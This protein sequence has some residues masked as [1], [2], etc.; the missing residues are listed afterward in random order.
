MKK[1]Y[2]KYR[3]REIPFR[4]YP[5][6]EE[7]ADEGIIEYEDGDIKGIPDSIF[8]YYYDDIPEEFKNLLLELYYLTPIENVPSIL[9]KG[10]LCYNEAYRI[11][12][13]SIAEDSVQDIRENKN[14]G[15]RPIHDYV[16][17]YFAKKTPMHYKRKEFEKNICYLCVDRS[18]LLLPGVYISDGNAAA[19]ETRF[20]CDLRKLKDI[21]WEL[22]PPEVRCYDGESKRKKQAEVLVPSKVPPDRIQKIVLYDENA[23]VSLKQKIEL[24]IPI[25]I[26]KSFYFY[27]DTQ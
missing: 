24:E 7:M 4:V 15:G 19:K 12:H 10:I 5:T 13:K 8:N 11:P 21:S 6:I 2:L 1:L 16:C 9:E 26:D 25:V 20:F 23:K 3:Y 17:L 14:I 22:F 18:I 27:E